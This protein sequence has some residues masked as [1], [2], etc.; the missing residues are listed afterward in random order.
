MSGA[1]TS[2]FLTTNELLAPMAAY[3]TH[4]NALLQQQQR[5]QDITDHDIAAVGQ[6]A[7][8]LLNL[9]EDDAAKAYPGWLQDAQSRGIAKYAPPTYPGHA[10]VQA[11]VQRALPILDQ[12][13]AGF[14]TTPADQ[15]ALQRA[16]PG[17]RTGAGTGTGSAGTGG[18]A[19]TIGGAD[20]APINAAGDSRTRKAAEGG[21]PAAGS[22]GAAVAQ[23][24]H[25]F[26]ISKGFSEPVVAGIM[27]GGPG[28]ES[29]FTPTAGGD[30]V[31]GV[32]TS[33]GLYQHHGVR[34]AN[35][36]QF[37][38]LPAGQM[39]TADQQNQY[40]H[41]EIT[42]GPLA[43]V[44]E[45]LKTAK[46]P[47]E[48]A[49]IWTQYFGV[50]ADKSEIGRRAAGAQRF[51]GLY[52]QPQQGGP[53]GATAPAPAPGVQMGQVGD[54]TAPPP[55]W[56][57]QGPYT[58]GGMG[59]VLAPG[60]PGGRRLTQAERL[61]GTQVAGPPMVASTNPTAATPATDPMATPPQYA[62]T[63]P[64]PSAEAPPQTGWGTQVG[65]GYG[66]QNTLA[67]QPPPQTQPSAQQPPPA[68][69]PLATGVNSPQ[70]QQGMQLMQQAAAMKLMPGYAVNPRLQA[71]AAWLEQQGQGL[72]KLETFQ[73]DTQGGV[74]GQRNVL[75]NQFTPDP[76]RRMQALQNGDVIN[77]QGRVIYHVDPMELE[78]DVEGQYWY[79]PKYP[80]KGPGGALVPP[81]PAGGNM[82]TPAFAEEQKVEATRLSKLR[83]E[84]LDRAKESAQANTMIANTET[85]LQEAQKGNLGA[86]AL[87]PQKLQIVATAKALG[88]NLAPFGI[89]ADKLG[90]A[91]VT[92]E[93]L[94]QLNGAILRKMYPQRITNAD[95]AISGTVL[96]NYGLDDQALT[97]N[98]SI[99]KKQND[100]DTR[101]AQ[102]MLDY[103]DQH[104]TLVGWENQWHKKAG[105]GAGPIDN[106]FGDA[107]AGRLT[108]GGTKTGGAGNQTQPQAPSLPPVADRVKGNTYPTARGP[109]VWTGTGWTIP[110]QSQ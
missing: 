92:R 44:G 35:M 110:E 69:A 72:M 17:L 20:T 57:A 51:V 74:H 107:Q 15:E 52:G 30:K 12:Y 47:A 108:S 97:S 1:Q 9:S 95:L 67:P 80:T 4:A 53:G 61:G 83:S 56:G 21:P 77:D 109:M 7:A 50:P 94:Q 55:P 81:Q 41:W 93:Q 90:A 45:M 39:P 37:F 104:H 28:S 58:G 14:I 36:Q 102:D 73:E 3:D 85:A 105:F 98:F 101:M 78:K 6:A 103:Q 25:D 84:V 76:A 60:G 99:Y 54:K 87:S 63:T 89:D 88:I 32:A 29:D 18:G 43:K 70:Y 23:Q 49:A 26:W 31:N 8:P 11:L 79:V 22:P 38:G 24:V 91:Q 13:K 34:L 2:P 62:G 27:A 46:T 82:P 68:R 16:F 66:P 42:Q 86:G 106:L 5:T 65:S 64:A 100:Y 33:Y 40:A 10:A 96:P 19:A 75:T 59:A 48:A 71:A